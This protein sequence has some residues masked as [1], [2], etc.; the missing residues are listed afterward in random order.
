MSKAEELNKRL[1]EQLGDMAAESDT[2]VRENA[3]TLRGLTDDK[4]DRRLMDRRTRDLLHL[5]PAKGDRRVMDR[6]LVK[7]LKSQN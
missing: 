7:D 5:V 6:R 4:G 3:A 1:L 2:I